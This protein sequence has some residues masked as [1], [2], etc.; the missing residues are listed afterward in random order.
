M[1]LRDLG[2]FAYRRREIDLRHSFVIG[3]LCDTYLFKQPARLYYCSRCRWSFLVA[4]ASI[5]VVDE[6]G[7]PLIGDES[8]RRF[9]SFEKGPCP[10]LDGLK[11]ELDTAATTIIP[12]SKLD[13]DE[14]STNNPDDS[15]SKPPRPPTLRAWL[16]SPVWRRRDIRW[17]V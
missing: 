5:A 17:Q 13:A 11:N 12:A 10:V 3:P 16:R 9:R 14:H 6:Q 1:K 15:N 4:G 7:R 8:K 2:P